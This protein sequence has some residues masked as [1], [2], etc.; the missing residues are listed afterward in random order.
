MEIKCKIGETIVPITISNGL[1]FSLNN[2]SMID[3][4]EPTA[5]CNIH[6]S[7]TD[8]QQI[9]FLQSK[10]EILSNAFKADPNQSCQ[11]YQTIEDTDYLLFDSNDKRIEN[12]QF[13]VRSADNKMIYDLIIGIKAN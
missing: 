5:P 2:L 12:V 9:A 6:F 13:S 1:D 3:E 7:T 8:V 10:F 4:N 11:V